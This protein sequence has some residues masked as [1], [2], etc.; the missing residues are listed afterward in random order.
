MKSI[1]FKKYARLLAYVRNFL[2]F[3]RLFFVWKRVG[4]AILKLF[5]TNLNKFEL[6]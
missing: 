3:C 2:Y 6:Y 1:I 4:V 5:C